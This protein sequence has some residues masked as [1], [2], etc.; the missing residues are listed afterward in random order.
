MNKFFEQNMTIKLVSL[1]V[2]FFLWIYVM[3]V[4]DPID[5]RDILVNTINFVYEGNNEKEFVP[6][7]SLPAVRLRLRGRSSDISK[8]ISNTPTLTGII[9]SP[10]VGSNRAVLK[11]ELSNKFSYQIIPSDISIDLDEL[12]VQSRPIEVVTFNKLGEGKE[13]K[14]IESNVKSTYIEG[15]ESQLN[16]VEKVIAKVDLAEQTEDF[17]EKVKLIPIDEDGKEVANISLNT[18]FVFIKVVVNHRKTVG[19]E[20][21]II[22]GSGQRLFLSAYK[23]TPD[24]LTLVGEASTVS[25]VDFVETATIRFEDIPGKIDKFISLNLPSGSSSSVRE[26]QL[27]R[28]LK[29]ISQKEIDFFAEDFVLKNFSDEEKEKARI[30]LPVIRCTVSFSKELEEQVQKEKISLVLDKNLRNERTNEISVLCETDL[31]IDQY[32]LDIAKVRLNE[33]NGF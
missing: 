8:L 3:G 22:D 26:V 4:V 5:T 24:S 7:G 21:T 13:V 1:T 18:E 31:P 10:K 28:D 33:E 32:V 6:I 29:N 14:V 11:A 20:P 16:R 25:K 15:A 12:K 23:V 17:S 30:S 19:I 9:T 2:S 27:Q